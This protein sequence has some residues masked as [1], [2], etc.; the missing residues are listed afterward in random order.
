MVYV[1]FLTKW[2]LILNLKIEGFHCRLRLKCHLNLPIN[3]STKQKKKYFFKNQLF[4]WMLTIQYKSPHLVCGGR[5]RV[6]RS[7]QKK[8][9]TILFLYVSQTLKITFEGQCFFCS[10]KSH[11]FETKRTSLLSKFWYKTP[12]KNSKFLYQRKKKPLWFPWVSI[13]VSQ[14]FS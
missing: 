2:N 11:A 5:N 12:K 3:V 7:I 10:Y 14:Q 8:K 6:H 1:L 4:E 9:T 13:M